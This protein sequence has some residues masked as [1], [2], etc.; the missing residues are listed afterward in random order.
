M[1]NAY[2]DDLC[3]RLREFQS[4]AFKNGADGK[5]LRR[6]VTFTWIG[7]WL[8]ENMEWACTR[9]ISDA[10]ELS[11]CHYLMK[12]VS[13]EFRENLPLRVLRC[14][15]YKIPRTF[16]DWSNWTGTVGFS[17]A[18]DRHLLM[19]VDLGPRDAPNA[20]IRFSSV[21]DNASAED[22]APPPL[23][24]LPTPKELLQK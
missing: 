5:P 13:L 15:G 16:D 17:R 2:T 10:A 3:P 1:A 18:S 22:K 23:D 9:D 21:P 19:E 6:S 8:G 12:D 20:A 11:L 14:Y 4:A 24:V 7:P